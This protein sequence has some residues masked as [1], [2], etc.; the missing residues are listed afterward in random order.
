MQ[1]NHILETPGG[2]VYPYVICDK[3]NSESKCFLKKMS[4][5]LLL[6]KCISQLAGTLYFPVIK[7][8]KTPQTLLFSFGELATKQ[9]HRSE[10]FT[11]IDGSSLFLLRHRR[12]ETESLDSFEP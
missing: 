11:L 4:P 8:N 5:L 7:Q 10:F 3:T 12:Q 1:L 6:S 2:C 9:N